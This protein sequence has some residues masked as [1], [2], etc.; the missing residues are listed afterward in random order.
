MRTH[1]KENTYT[2]SANTI[3]TRS[4]KITCKWMSLTLTH[5]TQ[6]SKHFRKWTPGSSTHALHPMLKQNQLH[7]SPQ[8]SYTQ[9]KGMKPTQQQ[10]VSNITTAVTEEQNKTYNIYLI[11]KILM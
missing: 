3:Y 7:R 10:N 11:N 6:Y 8:N 9:Q 1:R 5:I 4:A 2:H